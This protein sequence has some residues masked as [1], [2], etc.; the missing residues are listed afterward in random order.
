MGGAPS[1]DTVW[2]SSSY[3]RKRKALCKGDIAGADRL[4]VATS[5]CNNGHFCVKSADKAQS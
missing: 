4:E 5:G 3:T 1:T 2:V